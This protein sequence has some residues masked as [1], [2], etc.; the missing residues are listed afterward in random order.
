MSHPKITQ[1]LND[2]FTQHRFIFWHDDEGQYAED[3]SQLELSEV[4]VV[5]LDST[6]HLSIK[7]DI[8]AAHPTSKW[9]FYSE[10]P[11]PLPELDWLLDVRK[12]SKEFLTDEAS[13]WLEELGLQTLSLRQHIK[14]R[15]L[16]LRAKDRRERLKKLTE[17]DDQAE[18][19]DRKM[20]AVLLRAGHADWSGI[21]LKLFTGLIQNKEVNLNAEPRGWSELKT[22]G[23]WDSFW[24]LIKTAVGYQES[25]QTLRDLLYFML[26]SDFAKGISG[27][28]PSQLGHFILQERT[29]SA[30]ASVFLSQWRSNISEFESYNLISQAVAEDLKLDQLISEYSAEDLE[31]VATFMVVE[32]RIIRNLR[33]RIMAGGGSSLDSVRHIFDLRKDGHWANPKLAANN[34]ETQ[35][36]LC[37]YDA[38]EAGADFLAL[39]A[40]YKDGFRHTNALDLANLYLKELYRF[41]QTYRHLHRAAEQVD[42][43]GWS[44]L[45]KLRERIEDVYTGWFLPELGIAWGQLLEGHQGLLST[46][47]LDGWSKQI[48]FFEQQVQP[49]LSQQAVKRVF[50][51]ISDAFRYEAAEELSRVLTARNK[52]KVSLNSMLGVLPSYTTLG[53][54]SLLPHQ[55]LAY[56]ELKDGLTVT[57]DGMPTASLKDR[58]AILAKIGGMAINWEDLIALGKEKAREKFKEINVVYIYHDHIDDTGDTQSS[59]RQTFEAV[60]KTIKDLNDLAGFLVGNLN[61]SN[62]LITADHGFLYQEDK[63]EEADRSTLNIKEAN[64]LKKKK[65][66]VI[67]RDLGHTDKAW[68]GS[69]SITADMKIDDAMDFWVPKGATRFHFVGGARF[70]HGSAM[71]QEIVVPLITIKTSESGNAKTKQVNIMP[72]MTSYKVVNN[73]PRFE[74]I[75]TEAVAEKVLPLSVVISLRDGENLISNEQTVTFNSSSTSL[76]ERKKSVILTVKSGDF[77][78]KKDYYLVVRDA[79]SKVELHRISLKI[80]LALANDF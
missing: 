45:L 37:C 2:A 30:S 76:D 55:Q 50:V 75:Q 20:I 49:I 78:T 71:P 28:A 1:A 10:N 19:L 66:Y 53:M 24:N 61:A 47:Q 5:M 25:K 16:F 72:A 31:D 41:D 21:L 9:L 80:D 43:V 26:V 48:K 17:P 65:R 58:H 39:Q 15:A 62:I 11:A 23:L 33:D 14:D 79:D 34:K 4:R 44:L 52:F 38:L 67:G 68:C 7:I 40:Q 8:E 46:W 27:S 74:F 59:E 36:L 69:T 57:A 13:S 54:A 70:V 32:Q 3:I 64:A 35:A 22:Y 77:D 12:R 18:D 60:Q 6:P 56:K 29:K 63:I 73:L 51:I 42:L